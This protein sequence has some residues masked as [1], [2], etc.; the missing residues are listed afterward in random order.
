MCSIIFNVG[1]YD[2]YVKCAWNILDA[3]P[4]LRLEEYDNWQVVFP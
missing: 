2:N 1:K 4:C 3:S